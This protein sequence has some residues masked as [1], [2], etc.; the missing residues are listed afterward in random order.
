MTYVP[1]TNK[2]A[3]VVSKKTV[4]IALMFTA[5]NDLE[6]K[7][8]DILNAHVQAPVIRKVWTALGPEFGKDASKTALIVRALYGLK[9]AGAA[10]RSHFARC[11]EFMGYELCKVDPDLWLKP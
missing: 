5:L 11:M 2:Y 6:V 8:A 10:F 9:S 7:L 4:R 3:C 1:T